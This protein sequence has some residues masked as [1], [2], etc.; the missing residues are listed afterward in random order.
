MAN[1]TFHYLVRAV[2]ERDGRFLLAREKGSG[3]AFLPGGH[4]EAGEPATV[5]LQRELREELGIDVRIGAYVGA[6]EHAW[7]DA[8]G[9]A[10]QEINHVFHVAVEASPGVA[11]LASRERHLEFFWCEPDAFDRVDLRPKPARDLL[12]SAPR[13]TASWWASTLH[14]QND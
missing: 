6:I 5:A 14:P 1:A 8:A 4:V 9:T 12:A 11:E 2:V 13:T 10:H 7:R 3:F